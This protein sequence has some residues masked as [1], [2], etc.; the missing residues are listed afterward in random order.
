VAALVLHPPFPEFRNVSKCG[1]V[2]LILETFMA[3]ISG[4]LCPGHGR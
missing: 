2:S 3:G 4:Q 1:V